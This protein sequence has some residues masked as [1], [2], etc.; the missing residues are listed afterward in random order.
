MSLSQR[1]RICRHCRLGVHPCAPFGRLRREQRTGCVL[2]AHLHDDCNAA[3][4]VDGVLS[5]ATRAV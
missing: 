4:R 5:K 1:P 2:A 3:I